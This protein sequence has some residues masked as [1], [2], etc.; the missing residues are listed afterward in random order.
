MQ[1]QWISVN[2]CLL[3]PEVLRYQNNNNANYDVFQYNITGQ[4]KVWTKYNVY[5]KII[6]PTAQLIYHIYKSLSFAHKLNTIMMLHSCP[7]N[8]AP[9]IQ[10]RNT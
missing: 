8:L 10:R 7:F 4:I 2:T 9:A 5:D 1:F 3:R 6:R